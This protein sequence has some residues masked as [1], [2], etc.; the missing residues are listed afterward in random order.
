M[1]NYKKFW[2]NFNTGHYLN[3]LTE[4]EMVKLKKR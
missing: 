2:D 1:R 4:R 3:V